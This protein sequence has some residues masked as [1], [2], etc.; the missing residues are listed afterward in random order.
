MAD[1]VFHRRAHRWAGPALILAVAATGRLIS[2]E[3]DPA[4]VEFFEKKIRPVLVAH[5]YKCHSTQVRSP[6]GGL[7][8]DS[9]EGVRKGGDSGPAVMPGKPDASLLLKAVRYDHE[10]LRM[11]PKGKLPDEVVR[12]FERWIARGALDPRR[13]SGA[14]RGASHL[15]NRQQHWAFQPIKGAA[16][17][18][19]KD[20]AWPRTAVDHFVLA[21][22]EERGLSPSPPADKRTLIRRATYDLIGLPPTSEEVDLFL[23]DDS[24]DA[25]LRVVDRLLAS[26][27]YGERWGRH[28]LDVARYADTKDG[29]L[30]YGDDRVRPY[31]YT[32]R[33]YVIR[34]FN[35]DLP[36]DRFVHEQLAADQI[37]PKV[38]PGHLAAMGF[39]TLGRQ[40]DNNV[41]D[42]IDDRIDTVCRGL[43]GLTVACARCHDHK[44]DPIP[45]ADY[46]SLYGVF[47]S[48][49]APLELPLIAKPDQ[50]P[51]GAEFETRA[52]PKR[53]ELRKFLDSQYTLLLETARQ[54]VSD[55][56]VHV[57]TTKPDPLETAIFF[58]SLSPQDLRPQI[59][60]RW[61]RYLEGHAAPDDPVFGPWHDLMLLPEADFA[62]QVDSV[63]AGWRARPPGVARG[64]LN[65][66]VREALS[67]E[68][69]A[70]RAAVARTYGELLRSVYDQATTSPAVRL[71][72]APARGQLLAL[73]T[74]PDSPAFFPKS[75]T[76]EYMSR[77]EK[78]GFAQK[79]SALDRMAVKAVHAPPRAMVLHDL[80]PLYDPS[81]FVR[82]NPAH[83]GPGVPRQFLEVLAGD[84]RRPFPHGSGRLDLADAITAADNP[85]TSRVVVNRVWMHHFG[86]PLVENPGDFGTR[87]AAPLHPELLDFLALTMQRDAWSLK[88]LH[89]LLMR[90]STY[91]QASLER[92]ECRRIDPDNRWLWRM[93]RRR[94]DFEA[95]RDTLLALSGRLQ[96][97]LGGRPVDIAGNPKDLRRT[98]YGLVDRQSLPTLFRVFDFAS[99]DQSAERRPQTTAPQQA[100]FGLNSAF[101]LEQVRALA[102]CP[103]VAGET[104]PERRVAALYRRVVC[105]RPD[106]DEVQIALRFLAAAEQARSQEEKS[107]LDPWQQFAQVLLLM[108]ELMFVD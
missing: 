66:L 3:P 63:L 34:A 35:D 99:P 44:Y 95:V 68:H 14:A 64:Q 100:L 85:L 15:P 1:L 19:V 92:P 103:E 18:R 93:N 84:Q 7:L 58:L 33:D 37:E 74:R 61:R 79:V 67:K 26:P 23:A 12:D 62:G 88:K 20:A 77:M 73:L 32:Y 55:Y 8:L 72:D 70:G 2:G 108:N 78:D 47:A 65:P 10:T 89:R 27:H 38:E 82:G 97:K 75:R 101:T 54:R 16:L 21:R 24:P 107:Q 56:L 86:E 36:F 59:V 60:A 51:G 71:A 49:A 45:T 53:E 22:L 41:H 80:E 83:L 48:S 39:L 40:F 28:W 43:M 29:V 94:L 57:A 102:A 81:V 106:P 5:C 104:N 87:T 76:R 52:A 69:L 46:Y 4:G 6:K 96:R 11:P 13:S 9:R 90:S 31:A 30:M 50:T 105:R 98:V 91:Q 25:F 42:V 17:P